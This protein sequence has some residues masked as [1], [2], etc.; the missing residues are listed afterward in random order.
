MSY[1][2][3][4]AGSGILVFDVTLTNTSGSALG[5]VAYSTGL[6][7]D[8]DVYFDYNYETENVINN[9]NYIYATGLATAWT[10]GIKNTSSYA[11]TDWINTGFWDDYGSDENPI[12]GTNSEYLSDGQYSGSDYGDYTINMDWDLGGLAA[13]AS[14]TLT[15]DY[16]IAGTPALSISETSTPDAASTLALLGLAL[17]GLIALRRKLVL[18]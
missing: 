13:G 4:G 14:D 7:P 9:S 12:V 6:D 11:S 5:D 10:I 16:V 8:Q 18:A 2:K 15:Y 1:Q 3:S 17:A